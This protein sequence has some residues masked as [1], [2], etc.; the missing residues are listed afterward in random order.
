MEEFRVAHLPVVNNVD[1]IG[2][3]SD[4]DILELNDP[5]EPVGSF[6]LSPGGAYVTEG[7][8]IFEVM[9]VCDSHNLSIIPVLNDK[10]QYIGLI[11]MPNLLKNLTSILGITHPGG[12]IVLEINEKDYALTEIAHIVESNDAKILNLFVTS[13]PDSTKIDVT[14]KINRIDLSPVLQTFFRFNYIVKASWSHED[15]YNEGLR[16]RF[17]AL[18]NYLNI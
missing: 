7:Q 11:T 18:M 8:H 17:D 2:L 10:N 4:T 5:E 16:D 13:Y 1:F 14:L 15:A 12:I 3:I 9:K 6:P